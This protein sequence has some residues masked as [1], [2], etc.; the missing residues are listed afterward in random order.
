MGDYKARLSEQFAKGRSLEESIMN[1]I[2]GLRYD[3]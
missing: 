3:S 1:D 2:G